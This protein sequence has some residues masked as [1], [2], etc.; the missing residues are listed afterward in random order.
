MML[1]LHTYIFLHNSTIDFNLAHNIITDNKQQRYTLQSAIHEP[2]S[3]WLGI[4]FKWGRAFTQASE[5][6]VTQNQNLCI[7][8]G[9]PLPELGSQMAEGGILNPLHA[10]GDYSSPDMLISIFN[11]QN[12]QNIISWSSVDQFWCSLY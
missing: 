3:L 2:M 11:K 8:E 1:I 5:I 7:N 6:T 4:S 9:G 10:M 12:L